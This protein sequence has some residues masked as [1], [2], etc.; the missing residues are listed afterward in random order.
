M[1]TLSFAGAVVAAVALAGAGLAQQDLT[2]DPNLVQAG[3]YAVE[4]RHTQ[5]LFSVLHFGFTHYYGDFTGASGTLDIDPKHVDAAQV[6]V[7]IPAA[8]VS[9]TNAQLDGELK[10]GSWFDA[11]KYPNI[12]F[13]SRRVTQ[14]GPKTAQVEGD[15]TLHGVTR[16][17]TLDVS[18][19][20]AG[21]N[22]LSRQYTIGFD[23]IGKL[24]R[25]DFGVR[26]WE[27]LVGDD[28]DI[29]ISAAFE[30]RS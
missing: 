25:S 11:A 27:P 6:N 28:V 8:S 17:V 24:K 12:T 16:P 3:H 4:P 19:N 1:K 30:R 9:T 20:A 18:F 22:P 26:A 21:L 29:V 23:A 15:L 14:T 10:G 2:H 7:S 13:V 5:V